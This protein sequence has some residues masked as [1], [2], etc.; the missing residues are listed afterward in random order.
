MS[1]IAWILYMIGI[2]LIALSVPKHDVWL[3]L[4]GMS[5]FLGAITLL[6]ASLEYK[7]D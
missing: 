2:L 5:A 7:N 1:T 6:L 4:D 3:I